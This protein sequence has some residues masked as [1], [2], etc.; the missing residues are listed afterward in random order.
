[1]ST[2]SPAVTQIDDAELISLIRATQHRL[3]FI[4]PGMSD[5]VAKALCEQWQRIGAKAV[6]VILD[7]EPEV[8][9]LGYGTLNALQALQDTAT[10]L[11][12][13]VHHQPGIRIGMVIAD[14][15]MVVFAPVPLLVE[16]GSPRPLQ[17]SISA[18]SFIATGPSQ[19]GAAG[20]SQS[21]QDPTPDSSAVESSPSQS[22]RPNAIRLDFV[23][24]AIAKEVGLGDGGVRDQTVGQ[25]QVSASEVKKIAEDLTNN[26]P[27]KFD[28]ARKVRV[29]NSRFQFVEL[30]MTGCFISKKKVPI[31]SYLMGLAQNEQAQRC[32]H[33]NFDLIGETQLIIQAGDKQLSEDYLRQEKAKILKKFVTSIPG[34]GSVILQACKKKFDIAVTQLEDDIKLFQEGIKTELGKHIATNRD[35]LVKALLPGVRENPPDHYTKIHIKR[36]ENPAFALVGGM[37][38][39]DST[40]IP[41][42]LR[43]FYAQRIKE[44]EDILNDMLT[45]E[46]TEAFGQ[47]DEVIN[48]MRLKVVFKNVAYESLTDPK[49]I[50]VARKAMPGVDFLHEE[51]DAAREADSQKGA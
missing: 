26:P 27:V 46:I 13:T 41:G 12:T 30:E 38:L 15:A 22:C 11:G 25:N 49:F 43:D 39:V 7:V 40:K 48:A 31:P 5:E 36:G 1:M 45:Q 47:A 2:A 29:F 6:N 10:Q 51:Y 20:A 28:V 4:S 21:P 9:R 24:P 19:P 50:E 14:D 16:A 44:G 33:A 17:G 8:C 32:L 37:I 34:Y 23:P 42:A 18:P 35:A 3:V